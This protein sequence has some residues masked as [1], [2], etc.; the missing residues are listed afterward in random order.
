MNLLSSRYPGIRFLG[1]I[2][3]IGVLRHA[4]KN[5]YLRPSLTVNKHLTLK[6]LG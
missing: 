2:F 1:A 4:Q 5:A 3:E 6:D